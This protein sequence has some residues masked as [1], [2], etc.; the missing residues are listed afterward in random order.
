MASCEIVAEAMTDILPDSQFVQELAIK[1]LDNIVKLFDQAAVEAVENYQQTVATAENIQEVQE[2]GRG[3]EV[4]HRGDAESSG[5][6]GKEDSGRES[7]ARESCERRIKEILREK[8]FGT[9]K[10]R[11][12]GRGRTE[13][14]ETREAFE[15]R[16]RRDGLMYAEVGN[17]A[18]ALQVAP[19][20]NWSENAKVAAE[21]TAFLM[22][23][24]GWKTTEWKSWNTK[25][26]M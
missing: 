24:I 21:N 3:E 25:W 20:A 6:V 5:R 2:D 4:S 10:A 26:I 14:R 23:Y 7:S 19:E 16:S 11:T 22:F 1:Y 13:L 18:V 12:S 17:V 8:V 15:S 9:N